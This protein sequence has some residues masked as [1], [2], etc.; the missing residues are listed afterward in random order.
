M[1]STPVM[2]AALERLTSTYPWPE[3]VDD[4]AFYDTSQGL[5][6]VAAGD[7]GNTPI[8]K[9]PVLWERYRALAGKRT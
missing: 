6:A 7:R 2:R 3:L 4:W 1:R 9:N 5:R 8:V